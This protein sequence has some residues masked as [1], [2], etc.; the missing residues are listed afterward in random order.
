MFENIIG[1]KNIINELK[2]S[3]EK[4]S[5]PRALLFSGERYSGKMTTALE[6][7]R[8]VS[9]TK[10]RNW[11]CN[12]SSCQKYRLLLY[13]YLQI[14]GTASFMEDINLSADILKDTGAVS[15]HFMFIRSVRKLL[16]RFDSILWDGTESKYKQ[17]IGNAVKAEELLREIKPESN[18]ISIDDKFKKTIDRIIN[19]CQK[20]SDALSTENIPIDQIR[21]VSSWIHTAT[22]SKKII[23]LE[24]ADLM[25]D[26]SRN[27]LLKLLEEP[28][29][30]SLFILLTRRRGAIIPTILSRVRL[31]NFRDRT[32]EE[33]SIIIKKLFREDSTNYRNLKDFFISKKHNLNNTKEL[34]TSF[35]KTIVNKN[36]KAESLEDLGNFQTVYKNKQLF[37]IFTEECFEVLREELKNGLNHEL[38]GNIGKYLKEAQNRHSS[39]NQSSKLVI[40][41]LF[42]KSIGLKSIGLTQ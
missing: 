33:S 42:Y 28:P 21:R 4:D 2:K 20:T 11:T 26:S 7:A 13:P 23:I 14:L 25:I 39:L 37:N 6:L 35:I 1:Q 3:V 36:N 31:F 12:C 8:A 40:E 32:K 34:A 41:A 30:N 17:A 22:N 19:E 29:E 24:N 16:K 9:C 27:S 5:L 18:P 38:A 10:D 15:A